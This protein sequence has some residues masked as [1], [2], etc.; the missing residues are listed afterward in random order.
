MLLI[1]LI[2]IV[3]LFTGSMTVILIYKDNG[4]AKYFDFNDNVESF[5]CDDEII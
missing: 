1:I 2:S 3:F 5:I 4:D